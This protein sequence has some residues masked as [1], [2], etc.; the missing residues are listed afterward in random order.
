MTNSKPAQPAVQEQTS[1]KRG[2][3]KTKF[4]AYK[5]RNHAD[6]EIVTFPSYDLKEEVVFV[7]TVSAA[8]SSL[9]EAP[10][11]ASEVVLEAMQSVC[12]VY[13]VVFR[14]FLETHENTAGDLLKAMVDL[15]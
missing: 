15:F 5:K 10:A 14:V 3:C 9:P 1:Q 4:S 7:E 12:A 11:K 8:T 2:L 13:N 6:G